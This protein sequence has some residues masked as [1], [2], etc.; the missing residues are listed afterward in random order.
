M[1]KTRVA[2]YLSKSSLSGLYTTGYNGRMQMK[3]EIKK[4]VQVLQYG[5]QI[6]KSSLIQFITQIAE[7]SWKSLWFICIGVCFYYR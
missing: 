6:I 2:K 7:L 5:I 1:E 4:R 3:M